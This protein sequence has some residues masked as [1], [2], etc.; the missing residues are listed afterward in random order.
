MLLGQSVEVV[1]VAVDDKSDLVR[2]RA[3]AALEEINFHPHQ[4]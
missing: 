1:K 2:N 3:R 4:N